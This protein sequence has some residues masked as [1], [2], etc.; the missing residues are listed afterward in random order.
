MAK[1]EKSIVCLEKGDT[2]IVIARKCGHE[3]KIRSEVTI[4]EVRSSDYLAVNKDGEEWYVRGD[5]IKKK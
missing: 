1:K 3:F 4:K 2:A 5:E